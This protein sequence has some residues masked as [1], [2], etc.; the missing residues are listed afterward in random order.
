MYVHVHVHVHMCS[1]PNRT[2]IR[3]LHHL[4]LLTDAKYV[5]TFH[6]HVAIKWVKQCKMV[7]KPSWRHCVHMYKETEYK[8]TSQ[9]INQEC[10]HTCTCTNV[11]VRPAYINQWCTRQAVRIPCWW[12]LMNS[13]QRCPGIAFIACLAPP[14]MFFMYMYVTWW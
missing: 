7:T 14:D 1:V 5:Y 10:T 4:L 11:L 3:W 9:V 2:A 13:K 8:V 12:G 6:V